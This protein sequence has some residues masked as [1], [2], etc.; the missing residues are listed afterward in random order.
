MLAVSSLK[1]SD[2]LQPQQAQ[3][4]CASCSLGPWG[5]IGIGREGLLLVCFC[6]VVRGVFL[7]LKWN[8]HKLALVADFNPGNYNITIGFC[9]H[10][11][12]C[13]DSCSYKYYEV[14]I[15]N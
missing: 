3:Y 8:Q 10:L 12:N 13:C 4:T 7:R 9:A 11:F 5:G 14:A 15:K 6:C 2:A 1:D